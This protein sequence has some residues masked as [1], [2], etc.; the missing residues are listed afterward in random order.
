MDPIQQFI[1]KEIV[2]GKIIRDAENAIKEIMAKLNV[3]HIRIVQKT[4]ADMWEKLHQACSEAVEAPN[5]LAQ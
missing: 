2:V 1:D 4:M 5:H 3:D